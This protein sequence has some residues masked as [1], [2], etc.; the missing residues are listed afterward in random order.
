MNN[1][2]RRNEIWNKIDLFLV[3]A[4]Y[5]IANEYDKMVTGLEPKGQMHT[6]NE[7]LYI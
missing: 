1:K 2:D 5:A 6:S 7:K 3:T 4:K